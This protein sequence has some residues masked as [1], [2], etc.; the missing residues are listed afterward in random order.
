MGESWLREIERWYAVRVGQLGAEVVCCLY[1]VIRGEALAISR[2]IVIILGIN[3]GGRTAL[4]NILNSLTRVGCVDDV[5]PAVAASVSQWSAA[6][7]DR[8]T[9]S[10]RS[11][12]QL[13]S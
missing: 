4:E 11:R 3:P 1:S 10:T 13:H 5:F 9:S 12:S 8:L 2:T 6:R 7:M